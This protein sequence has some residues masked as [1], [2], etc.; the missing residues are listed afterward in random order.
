MLFRPPHGDTSPPRPARVPPSPRAALRGALGAVGI[1]L[2]LLVGPDLAPP[3]VRA[4]RLQVRSRATLRVHVDRRDDGVHLLGL[5]TDDAG[6]G[7]GAQKVEVRVRGLDPKTVETDPTGAFDVLVR[8]ADAQSLRRL[9]GS[10]LDWGVHL[11]ADRAHG[12]ADAAGSLDL[13]RSPTT[14]ALDLVP[15]HVALRMASVRATVTLTAGG[16]SVARAPVALQVGSGPTISG[17][18]GAAGTATFRL[19]PGALDRAGVVTVHAA[20]EGNGR[21]APAQAQA[22]L[23]V[24]RPTRLTLRVGREGSASRGRYRFSG[25][26]ADAQGPL[27]NAPVVILGEP[28][29]APIDGPREAGRSQGPGST[30]DL[31]AGDLRPE[32]SEPPRVLALAVTDDDGLF[33]ATTTAQAFRADVGPSARVRAAYRPAAA[34]HAPAE[35]AP[36]AIAIPATGGVPATWY[37]IAL[38][39]VLGALGAV[40]AAGPARAWLRSRRSQAHRGDEERGQAA[41]EEPPLLAPAHDPSALARRDHIAGLLVDAHSGRPLAAGTVTVQGPGGAQEAGALREARPATPPPPQ[42]WADTPPQPPGALAR[43]PGAP[44]GAPTSAPTNVL[45]EFEL[46]PLAPGRYVLTATCSDYATRSVT[47]TCPHGGELDG[48]RVRLVASRRRVR[49]LFFG[50]C[51][52]LRVDARWGRDTPAEAC[53]ASAGRR[54]P[55]VQPSL[56]ALR[57]LTEAAWFADRPLADGDVARAEELFRSVD[58]GAARDH[59]GEA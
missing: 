27:A 22:Q 15:A 41:P 42:P 45:G 47:V 4:L 58:T 28:D 5:A 18:T 37:A 10:S 11:P 20:Y 33:L 38:L 46:G 49:D 6:G 26:L 17:A 43:R 12:R 40:R 24:V 13:T 2:G 55:A 21:L 1:L 29:R 39:W 23:E 35:S 16:R 19:L 36:V 57:E 54:A 52:A 44:T 51:R 32:S 59:Q 7:L 9:H 14:M 8:A 48:V 25:R 53:D 34:T 31:L 3:S 50:A 30:P 56:A